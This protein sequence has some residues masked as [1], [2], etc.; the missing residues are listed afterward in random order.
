MPVASPMATTTTYNPY[1][2]ASTTT[3]GAQPVFPPVRL[4]L[5]IPWLFYS[6]P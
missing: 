6:V 2:G 5:I 1:T 4:C 3:Y